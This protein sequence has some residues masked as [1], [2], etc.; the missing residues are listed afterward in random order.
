MPVNL[1]PIVPPFRRPTL[2]PFD[3]TLSCQPARNRNRNR[4][5]QRPGSVQTALQK[6]PCCSMAAPHWAAC[7]PSDDGRARASRLSRQQ[8]RHVG[9]SSLGGGNPLLPFQP[10]PQRAAK[11]VP[12]VIGPVFGQCGNQEARLTAVF[13]GLDP[14]LRLTSGGYDQ[15]VDGEALGARDAGRCAPAAR[16][17]PRRCRSC[18]GPC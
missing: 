12:Q 7:G 10:T 11:G 16:A 1:H 15:L 5:C 14:I 17:F 4:I 6:A 3:K 2:T 18:G 8:F 9:H 13:L